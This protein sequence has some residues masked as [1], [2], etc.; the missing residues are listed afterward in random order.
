LYEETAHDVYIRAKR[1]RL[2]G[3]L[4]RAI[5]DLTSRQQQ[6]A[7]AFLQYEGATEAARMLGIPRSTLVTRQQAAFRRLRR[8]LKRDP[9]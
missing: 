6:T 8:Q 5:A 4:P 9:R 3:D 1:S 7:T 2:S